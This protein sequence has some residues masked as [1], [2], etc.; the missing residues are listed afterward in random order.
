MAADYLD[1]S[2][3]RNQ[4]LL[5]EALREPAARGSLRVT[6]PE[7]AAEQLTWLAIAAPLNELTLRAGTPPADDE[8]L[9]SIATEAVTTFLARFG[10]G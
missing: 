1:R 5:A 9:A 8:H 7:V 10:E 4:R 2:W 6:V 3:D